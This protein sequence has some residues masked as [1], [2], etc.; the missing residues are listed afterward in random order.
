MRARF[1][2]AS[3][4]CLILFSFG[5]YA[6]SEQLLLEE[7]RFAE[8][9][10]GAVTTDMYLYLGWGFD[11]KEAM[12]EASV[13]AIADLEEI[14]AQLSSQ[15]FPNTYSQMKEMMLEQIEMLK[16]I[17]DGIELK[18]DE[19]LRE[20][21]APFHELHQEYGALF[22]GAWLKENSV[23]DEAEPI[24]PERI[25]LALFSEENRE[26]Y[27]AALHLLK[28]EKYGKAYDAL[29]KL[30]AEIKD[31]PTLSIVRLRLSD[32]LLQMKTEAA[33]TRGLD[34]AAIRNDG[35]NMLDSILS[36]GEYSPGLYEVFYKWR[37]TTQAMYHGM[38]NL[39]SI[40]N[41]EYNKRRW[42]VIRVIKDYLAR[43]PEDAWAKAQ[44]DLLWDLSNIQRGGPMGNDNLIHWGIL[45]GNINKDATIKEGNGSS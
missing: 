19:D 20:E 2:T 1:F 43:N 15:E 25:E 7:L 11:E 4:A 44:E 35:L 21:F 14:K 40:P 24:D 36:K 31:Y 3:L 39:S 13:K 38:S 29:R 41:K 16:Q 17:Y 45:Y 22:K 18:E 28:M 30:E 23:A 37:T 33:E 26:A 32:S 5:A 12:K 27:Q 8:G 9:Q 6:Q 42:E 34:V 10:L